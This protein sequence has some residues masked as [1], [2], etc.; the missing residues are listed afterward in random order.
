[1]VVDNIENRR[2]LEELYEELT[3]IYG[4]KVAFIFPAADKNEYVSEETYQCLFEEYCLLLE[5]ESTN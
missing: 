3:L 2:T 5:K 4:I 1:M